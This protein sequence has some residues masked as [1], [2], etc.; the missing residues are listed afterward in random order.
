MY[1]A[2]YTKQQVDERN[3]FSAKLANLPFGITAYDLRELLVSVNA[4]T[5]FIPRTNDKYSRIRYAYV[6]FKS[7]EDMMA[8]ISN[9]KKFHYRQRVL[10]WVDTDA[11]TSTNVVVQNI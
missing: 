5:C 6:S 9:E 2:T 11:K 10:Y 4:Q 1:P 8:A 7:E 3:E